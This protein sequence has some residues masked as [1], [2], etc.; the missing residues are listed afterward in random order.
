MS[1]DTRKRGCA[2][3]AALIA[4]CVW[5][6]LA[7]Q[8]TAAQQDTFDV[9]GAQLANAIIH[10]KQRSVA[11]LDFI[12][13]GHQ[14]SILGQRLA[15]SVSA[16]IAKA[17][18]NLKVEDRSQVA[19]VRNR[20][21]YA[22]EIVLDPGSLFAFAQDLKVEAI[23]TGELSVDQNDMLQVA[24]KAYRMSN[25]KGI[26]GLK[27]SMPLIPEMK[28]LISQSA[29]APLNQV[30]EINAARIKE[31]YKPV[32]CLRCPWAN[33]TPEAM[34]DGVQGS[35][36]LTG[37]VDA[38]GNLSDISVL[39]ALPDGLTATAI[40]TLKNWKLTPATAPDGKPVACRE[41]FMFPFRLMP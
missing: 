26:L 10:K 39:K 21:S 4:I 25:G 40:S 29:S 19:A 12:G 37:I 8:S 35:V 7:A 27:V 22:L 18:G 1:V 34:S 11:V 38:S 17:G 23:V 32:R 28:R 33:Y 31:G 30:L 5:V 16:A 41:T 2:H 20:Y 24:L 15:D 6:P 13:P 9:A 36:E 3:F 14:V